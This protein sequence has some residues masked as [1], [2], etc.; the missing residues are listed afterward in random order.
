MNYNEKDNKNNNKNNI[1][2][3]NSQNKFSPSL[4][5]ENNEKYDFNSNTLYS[6]SP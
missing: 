1:T 6:K 2:F 4:F 5:S 3:K